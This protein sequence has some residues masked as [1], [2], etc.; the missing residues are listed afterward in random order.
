MQGFKDSIG[1]FQDDLG[2]PDQANKMR[3]EFIAK[4]P[5]SK[6]ASD[7]RLSLYRVYLQKNEQIRALHMLR[8]YLDHSLPSDRNYFSLKQEWR[9]LAFRI[10]EESLR[11]VLKTAGL[12]DRIE[13][14]QNMMD[15]MCLAS[16]SQP[17]EGLVDEIK[18][19]DFQEE[20]RWSLVYDAAGRMYQSFPDKA[21]G[22]FN[23][24]A[25]N[26]TGSA[27]VSSLLTLGNIAYRVSK[28]VEEAISWYEKAEKLLPLTD[29]LIETPSYR[30][31][32]LYLVQ[33]EGLKGLE[34]LRL[35][36]VRFPRSRHL[37]KAYRAMG[38]ACVALNNPERALRY[39]RRILRISPKMA[40]E[41]NKLIAEAEE[42]PTSEEWLKTRAAQLREDLAETATIG[43]EEKADHTVAKKIT[44]ADKIGE[45]DLVR[46]NE[47]T[48]YGLFLDEVVKQKPD[49]ERMVMFLKEVLRRDKTPADLR[50]RAL[51]Q[52][53][54][55]RFFRFRRAEDFAEEAQQ[56]LIRSNY[57]SWQSEL[58]FRLAQ[59]REHF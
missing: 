55:T 10:R 38:D 34:K 15:V 56:M 33:G 36:T 48:V 11:K 14:Y 17:L 30:L 28:N 42:L 49:E 50:E 1:I 26:A 18:S 57:A 39:Y 32:R 19:S 25:N 51:R 43:E 58:L 29:P 8:D 45:E 37:A 53:I 24:L 13:I 40:D 41:V 46:Y 35:F 6:D 27:Q 59:A 47:A 3:E 31:G 12:R 5:D 22:L 4:Y 52:Y 44:N 54:S 21:T 9:D 20:T 23:E 16:S 2:D 7:Y